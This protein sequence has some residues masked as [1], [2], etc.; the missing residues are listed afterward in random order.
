VEGCTLAVARGGGGDA[1]DGCRISEQ[2]LYL[3]A[4]VF[5]SRIENVFNWVK[6]RV[7][8]KPSNKHKLGTYLDSQAM[9]VSALAQGLVAIVGTHP[10]VQAY[11]EWHRDQ[12]VA[13][14]PSSNNSSPASVAPRNLFLCTFGTSLKLF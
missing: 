11:V 5:M 10:W 7:S 13:I 14:A 2:R 6:L 12:I 4:V 9:I 8:D 1:V 3:V